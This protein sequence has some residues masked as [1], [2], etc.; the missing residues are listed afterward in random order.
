VE[1]WALYVP[2][3]KNNDFLFLVPPVPL[4]GL[5]AQLVPHKVLA[6]H[7]TP[8]LLGSVTGACGPQYL[9]KLSVNT[10]L[11][12]HSEQRV[13]TSSCAL[14][15]Q[16]RASLDYGMHVIL[17]VGESNP[18]EYQK[19]L[20]SQLECLIQVPCLQVSIAYEPKWAIGTGQSCS[21]L[22]LDRVLDFIKQILPAWNQ[23]KIYY[24]GS[25]DRQNIQSFLDRT[26]LEGLLLGSMSL[27]V[28][29]ITQLMKDMSTNIEKC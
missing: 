9:Q 5:F 12:G 23:A 2:L 6:S 15:A 16:I 26:D 19:E 14:W 1:Q 18:L 8:H 13:Y 20:F 11:L 28:D 29:V 4:L 24:G 10:V 7:L 25:L 3:L 21:M 27:N 22:H 17:C